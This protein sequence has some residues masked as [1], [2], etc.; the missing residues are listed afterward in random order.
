MDKLCRKNNFSRIAWSQS[1]SFRH[2]Q[3]G[4]VKTQVCRKRLRYTNIHT[5]APNQRCRCVENMSTKRSEQL[6]QWVQRVRWWKRVLLR[7]KNTMRY[8]MKER[9]FMLTKYITTCLFVRVR[10]AFKNKF[11]DSREPHN[12]NSSQLFQEFLNTGSVLDHPRVHIRIARTTTNCNRVSN[13]VD[14]AHRLS[15]RRRTQSLKASC[16]VV[17]LV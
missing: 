15:T 1:W 3:G 7:W 10:E 13:R 9:V 8:S 14:N 5:R 11:L 6:R 4:P 12:H 16:T 2:V 17:A